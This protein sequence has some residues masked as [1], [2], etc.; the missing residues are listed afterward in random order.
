MFEIESAFLDAAAIEEGRW[1]ALGSEFPGVEVLVKGLTSTEA[2]KYQSR[3]QRSAPRRDRLAN[4]RLTDEA[5][6]RI[7]KETVIE[8][9]VMD[10][11]GLG[12][13]GKPLPF[14]KEALTSFMT[15]PKAR[16]IAVAI[17]TAIT[18]LEQT[19]A[20]VSEEVA[21]N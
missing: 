14:S 20:E 15:E 21:G 11:R 16:K 6:E 8:K 2:Q 10:W 7:L 18:D 1:V 3:A 17:I 4:G 5:Q 13:K 12:S 9:C 19:M